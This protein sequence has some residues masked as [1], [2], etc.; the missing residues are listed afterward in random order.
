MLEYRR[1]LRG[2]E[3]TQGRDGVI[4]TR[5]VQQVQRN[6]KARERTKNRQKFGERQ[7]EEE[8]RDLLETAGARQGSKNRLFDCS[9]CA[10]PHVAPAIAQANTL[11]VAGVGV[12][13]LGI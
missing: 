10:Q 8:H 1:L 11:D 13:R 7:I 9:R 6:R 2:C 3:E 12:E 4:L 5:T